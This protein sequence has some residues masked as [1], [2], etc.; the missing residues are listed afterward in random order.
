MLSQIAEIYQKET[1]SGFTD[2][3]TGLYNHGFF[4]ATL[5]REI[6]RLDRHGRPFAMGLVDIDE[7]KLQNIRLG[8]LQCDRILKEIALNITASIRNVDLAA[9]YSG[10]QFAVILLGAGAE[11]TLEIGERIRQTIETCHEGRITASVG[12][13]LCRWR[14]RLT[15]EGII[16]D[17]ASALKRAK[18]LGKNKVGIFQPME[19]LSTTESSNIL[20]VDDEPLNLK[21]L[22]ALLD[23]SRYILYTAQSGEEAFSIL[24][25]IDIDLVLLDIMMPGIDGFEICNR[26]KSR[27]ETRMTPVI[28]VT[29]LDSLEI[30]VRGIEAGADDFITKPPNRLELAARVKSLLKIKKLNNSLTSIENVLFSM[31]RT[32]EAKDRYTHGHVDRVSEMAVRIGKCM[33]LGGYELEALRFGGVFHDI[34]KM[35]IPENILNKPGP[36]NEKE[37]EVMK[38]HPEIGYKICLPLK[39]NLGPALD[40]VRHHHEKLDGSGYPDG[41][42]GDDISVVARI[43][44]V[45]DIYDA[46]RTDRPYRKALSR[47]NSLNVLRENAQK[48][49][50]DSAVV[51][52]M[53][54]LANT[55]DPHA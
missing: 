30:K 26:I 42:T 2:N 20:I 14:T 4:L 55:R 40:I 7:F 5:D 37:W 33:G 47:M 31:A 3:L 51:G 50:L 12:L 35:G 21:L 1:D 53:I 48:G 22:R 54:D 6:N 32:V 41:L 38:T 9:R 23:N 13:T 10:D 45:A 46:L 8:V 19:I 52:H 36:L 27:E 34:G 17:A 25:R 28:L 43:M 18:L 15:R 39:R 49:E 24:N 29:A 11:Q 16:R 44:T